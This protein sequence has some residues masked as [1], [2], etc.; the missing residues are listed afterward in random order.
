VASNLPDF[1]DDADAIDERIYALYGRAM[2]SAQLLE[3]SIFQLAQLAAELPDDMDAAL[4]KIDK[5]LREA[6]R[7]QASALGLP[8]PLLAD[9]GDAL[10]LRNKFAHYFLFEYRLRRAARD[11]WPQLAAQILLEATELFDAINEELDAL[12]D[13][14]MKAR[15]IEPSLPDDEMQAL[16]ETLADFDPSED[17]D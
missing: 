11:D 6:A 12:A 15:G 13:A 7:R 3:F 1:P 14:D 2:H 5:M 4:R 9:I 10:D 8:P 16:M 17:E